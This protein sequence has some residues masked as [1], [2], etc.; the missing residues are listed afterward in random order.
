MKFLVDISIL[1]SYSSLEAIACS[2]RV[3]LVTPTQVSATYNLLL[4]TQLEHTC[5]EK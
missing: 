2:A 3:T 5:V 1:L 4:T